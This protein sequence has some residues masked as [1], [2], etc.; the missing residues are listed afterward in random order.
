[1]R[2]ALVSEHADPLAALGSAG[3]LGGSETGGQN[4]HVAALADA[5]AGLGHQV[6]VFTRWES[7][8]SAPVVTVR[9]GFDVVRVPAG[10]AAP[11]PRDEL[12]PLMPEFGR[13]LHRR[14]RSGPVPDVVHAHFWMSGMAA[15][16][17]CHALGLPFVQTFHALGVVKHRHQGGAD[18]S[19]PQRIQV[20]RRLARHADA[21]VATCSDEVRELTRMGAPAGR[22]RVVPCGV[23]LTEFHPHGPA[24]PRPEGGRHR[25]V[26]LG[27]LVERKGVDTLVAAMRALP[28]T[29]LL[30]AGGPPAEQL[31]RDP[32]ARRLLDRI[33]AWQVGDRVRL[34]GRV[35][36]A[37]IPPLLRSADLVASVPAYEP[38]G[39]VPVEAMACG[40]PV[41]AS[42]VG[43]MLDTV[44]PGVTGEHVPPGDLEA[45][46]TTIS[47]L[48]ADPRRRRRMATRAAEAA[49]AYSWSAVAAATDEVYRRRLQ[50]HVLAGLTPAEG[51]P[52]AAARRA[53]G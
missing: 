38:F 30:V 25:V 3:R 47:R 52:V 4:V 48:L 32:D 24:L 43:G 15:M 8:D 6:E 45:L 2:I 23:D 28:D 26:Y 14:W 46:H 29:E 17:V 44:Q 53:A 50:V 40:V 7:P 41:V 13:W 31:A 16:P 35:D 42:A 10:P 21:V 39:I 22:L 27:R 33:A 9:P 49:Q 18:T 36:R 19:P 34:L 37:D 11:V 1:M 5:L 51:L 20:E 12:A